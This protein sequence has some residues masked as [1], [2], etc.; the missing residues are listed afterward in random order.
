MAQLEAQS[1][2]EAIGRDPSEY[3]WFHKRMKRQIK[4]FYV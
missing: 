1:L 2:E 4:H 3:F